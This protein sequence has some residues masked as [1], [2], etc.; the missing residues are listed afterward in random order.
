MSRIVRALLGAAVVAGLVSCGAGHRGEV[1]ADLVSRF[2]DATLHAEIG[3]IDVGTAAA[4]THLGRGWSFDENSDH[5]TFAWGVGTSSSVSFFLSAPRTLMMRF[6][7]FSYQVPGSVPQTITVALNGHEIGKVVVSPHP[8]DYRL[9]LPETDARGGVNRLEFRYS[10]SRSPFEVS[11]APDVRRLAVGWD[12]LRF[13]PLP[14]HGQLPTVDLSHH[15]IA[16]APGSEIDYFLRVAP[17][18]VLDLPDIGS[19]SR[20]SFRLDVIWKVDGHDERILAS[21]EAREYHRRIA[22]PAS[23]GDPVELAFRAIETKDGDRS[24]IVLDSPSIQR[25]PRLP[26][27]RSPASPARNANRPRPN[28]ILYLVDTLRADELGCYG[29]KRPLTPNVDSL[30]A[31]GVV[32]ENAIAQ[33]SW[34]KPAVTSILTGLGPTEHGVN[35]IDAALRPEAT[36]LAEM[37]ST[38]GYE[39]AAFVTNDYIT[40]EAGFAQG[41]DEFDSSDTD[42]GELTSRVLSWLD[43]NVPSK[44]LFLYVHSVDPH[45]PYE[46]PAVWRRRFARGVPASVGSERHLRRMRRHLDPIDDASVERIRKLYDAEVASN[47]HSFGGLLAGL[48]ARGLGDDTVVVF[49]ADHGEEFAEHGALGHGWDLHDET[50]H[51]PLIV[52]FPGGEHAGLVSA[53][54]QQIDIVPTLLDYLGVPRGDLPLRGR[55]LMPLVEGTPRGAVPIVSYM[56]YDSREAVSVSFEAWKLIEPLSPGYWTPTELYRSDDPRETH[57][58]AEEFPVRSGFLVSFAKRELRRRSASRLSA[59]IRLDDEKRQRLRALGYL[60]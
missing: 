16:I 9:K 46:P 35:S 22:I 6:R 40:R 2:P 42:S 26:T 10:W 5:M 24:T 17:R 11:R 52:R 47:D 60:H 3:L 8:A 19:D 14:E 30:A 1:A 49:V 23:G 53:P 34:T 56:N 21:L 59:S 18:S 37:L 45:E 55:S 20:G 39:T 29:Q 58:L 48:E 12:W 13:D 31:K 41:F 25:P 50:L 51:V 54:V 27:H 43:S 36:T 57:N 33:S 4:R 32:F 44:P 15:A 28:V 38:A 7:C